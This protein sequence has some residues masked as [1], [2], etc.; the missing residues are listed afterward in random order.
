MRVALMTYSRS[1]RHDGHLL[2]EPAQ[3]LQLPESSNSISILNTI[4]EELT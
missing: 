2:I 4:T 3:A 1:E